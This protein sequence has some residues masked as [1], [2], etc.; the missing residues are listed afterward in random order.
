[1]SPKRRETMVKICMVGT[2]EQI[3]IDRGSRKVCKSG[4]WPEAVLARLRGTEKAI[5]PS[6]YLQKG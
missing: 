2:D 5:R 4:K 1:M 3:M 6:S